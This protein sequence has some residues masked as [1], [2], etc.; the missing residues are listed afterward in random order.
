M[1]ATIYIVHCIDTEGPLYESLEATFKR[2]KH[3]FHLDLEPSKELLSKLQAGKYPLDGLENVVRKV[4]APQLLD[5]NDT[6]VK[7]DSM[8]NNVLSHNF[9]NR[10]IDSKGNGWVYNWFCLDHVGYDTNPCRRDMGYH[11]IF[12]HYRS[13]LKETGSFQDGI[14]F[15]FHPHPFVN[16][17]NLCATHWWASS[18][19]LYQ[20][21][22]RRIIDRNWFPSVNRPGFHV[23]RPDSH[24][25][26]EQFI[27]FD[28]PSQAIDTNEDDE[29]Q[30]DI[31]SGRFGDWRR[32]PKTWE[33]YHPSYDDYQTPGNCRRWIARCL[34]IGSRLKELTM[35]EVFQAAEEA[36]EGKPVVM[37]FSNHDFRDIAKDVNQVHLMLKEMRAKY[38]DV[39]FE[40]CE[41]ASAMR[42]ALDLPDIPPC[43][44]KIDLLPV[45][46]NAHILKVQSKI[47]IFG[48]QPYLAIKTLTQTYH[49]DNF[50]FQQP[51]HEWTYVFD[52]ETFPLKAIE[53]IGVAT[54]NSIGITTVITFDVE[55]G[56]KKMKIWNEN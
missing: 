24:W 3:I 33:P 21:L 12:D 29:K 54:N 30:F 18:D 9:R 39:R 40:F 7:L 27:P 53:K 26:L 35:K 13:V 37:A 55:T 20:V 45:N 22:S 47:P 1:S 41:A 31:S 49:H 38:P 43:E 2:L 42:R 11:N 52:K 5:Y 23:T 46:D 56:K 25:F 16:R 28:M 14:H 17:A 34:N 15:H 6:W 48:P 44:L 4:V 32:A 8:L 19:K 10:L 50:D 51:H 36:L